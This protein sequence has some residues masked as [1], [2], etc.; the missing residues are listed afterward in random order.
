MARKL[1]S[2]ENKKRRLEDLEHIENCK[3]SKNTLGPGI[4]TGNMARNT[5]NMKYEKCTL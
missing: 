1:N 3:T 2:E 4:W 5:K